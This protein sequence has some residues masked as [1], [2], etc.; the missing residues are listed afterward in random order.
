M[1]AIK[2]TL[3]SSQLSMIYEWLLLGNLGIRLNA[4]IPTPP[5][6]PSNYD[7]QLPTNLIISG[8][9]ALN[10]Q[11]YAQQPGPLDKRPVQSVRDG[12]TAF[13]HKLPRTLIR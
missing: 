9:G 13:K 11:P 5:S 2:T 10:V 1:A 4:I 7:L 3:L 6:A 8:F 12:Y